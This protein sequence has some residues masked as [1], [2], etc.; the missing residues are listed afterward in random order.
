MA[1]MKSL[2]LPVA[3]ALTLASCDTLNRPLSTSGDFDP[4]TAPGSLRKNDLGQ[5][6]GSSFSPGQFVRA[7][8]DNTAFFVKRPRGEGDADKLLKLGTQMKVIST[9]GAYLKVELDSGEVGYVASVL[10]TDPS[11][12]VAGLPG[13]PGEVQVYPPLPGGP[14]KPI[15]QSIPLI[16]PGETPP[17]G[18]VPTVIDPAAPPTDVPVPAPADTKAPAEHKPAA[19]AAPSA[20]APAEKPAGN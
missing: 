10:V 4:L 9:D 6:G 3:A 14:V 11:A 13:A 5:A 17:S 18:A 16:P 2:L 19:E 8:T 1:Q 15:D 12:P 20:E 7:V